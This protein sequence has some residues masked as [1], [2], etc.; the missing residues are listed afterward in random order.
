MAP[1]LTDDPDDPLQ[2]TT[3]RFRKSQI[4]RAK[5]YALAHDCTLLDVVKFALNLAFHKDGLPPFDQ[6]T[7][8]L[9]KRRGRA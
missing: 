4:R 2:Q 9:P 5:E 6:D 7:T 8:S 3:L 1:R